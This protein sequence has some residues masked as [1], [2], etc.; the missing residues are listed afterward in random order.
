LADDEGEARL[1]HRIDRSPKKGKRGIQ[2]E[3]VKGSLDVDIPVTP[4]LGQAGL[5]GGA[6]S[7]GSRRAA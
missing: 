5:A 3:R 7:T 2:I 4:K 1:W 6:A